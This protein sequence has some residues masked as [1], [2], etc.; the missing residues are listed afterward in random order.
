MA[1]NN[2]LLSNATAALAVLD[3]SLVNKGLLPVILPFIPSNLQTT[4]ASSAFTFL[5]GGFL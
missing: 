1:F 2:L 4:S 3:V 5:W